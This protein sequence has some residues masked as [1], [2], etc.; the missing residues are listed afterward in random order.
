MTRYTPQHGFIPT[1]HGSDV[2]ATCRRLG[3]P[4]RRMIRGDPEP[5]RDRWQALGEALLQGDPLMDRVVEWMMDFGMRDGHALFCRAL[6]RGIE[7]LPRTTEALRDLFAQVD[8]KPAWLNE[9]LTEYG[10]E[11]CHS[12]GLTGLRV[13]RNISLMCG[14][15][16][17]AIN[18]TLVLTGSLSRGPS[19]AWRK[20]R[21]GSWIAPS[22]SA[23]RG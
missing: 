7:S 9:G 11:V 12:T 21:N 18:T 16:A 1:R 23:W 5:T 15:Q 19:G 13:L 8:H 14:Y 20:P 6:E 2:V 22:P 4:I 10:N 3:R 17:S